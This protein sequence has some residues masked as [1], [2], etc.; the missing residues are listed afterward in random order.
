MR[1]AMSFFDTFLLVFAGIGLVVACFTI[2]NTFQIVVTQRTREMALLRSVG[3]TRAQV[4]WSQL[5]EALLAAG[6]DVHGR[7]V[8]HQNTP[9][10]YARFGGGA[11]ASI[12][13]RFPAL[14]Q[15]DTGYVGL[16]FV[17]I[18]V[19]FLVREVPSLIG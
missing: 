7:D 18:A 9:S 13:E 3:A 19:W 14:P 17:V 1:E 6:A 8:E 2:Y 10:G 12:T 15:N 11:F 16:L 4:L 5:I